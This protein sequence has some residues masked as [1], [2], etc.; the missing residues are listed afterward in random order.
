MAP[1]LLQHRVT[2]RE[3]PLRSSSLAVAGG[4]M[5]GPLCHLIPGAP[6][7]T[8]NRCL[9]CGARACLTPNSFQKPLDR[10]T[11]SG[12]DTVEPLLMP[13]RHDVFPG[14]GKWHACRIV[15]NPEFVPRIA[16]LWKEIR[17]RHG[18]ASLWNRGVARSAGAP[19]ENPPIRAKKRRHAPRIGGFSCA[20]G[21]R[22]LPSAGVFPV[23]SAR[24]HE[25]PHD[26]A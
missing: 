23:H 9:E 5:W 8:A 25:T 3:S 13:L 18:F 6:L 1:Y 21:L 24:C 10:G 2:K 22:R 20:E 4:D 17:V 7:A 12:L 15:F 16:C 19:H 14:R 11:N 26:S